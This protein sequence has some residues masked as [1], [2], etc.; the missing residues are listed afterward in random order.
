MRLSD[1]QVNVNVNVYVYSLDIP[2]SSAD[3]TIYTPGIGTHSYTVSSPLGRIQRI[4]CS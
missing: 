4:F 3:C 1:Q 2:S